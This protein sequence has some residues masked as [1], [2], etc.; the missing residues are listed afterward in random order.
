MHLESEDLVALARAINRSRPAGQ[1][2]PAVTA[3][4][5]AQV[6]ATARS[7]ADLMFPHPALTSDCTRR[8]FLTSAGV[9]WQAASVRPCGPQSGCASEPLPKGI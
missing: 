5:E 6:D 3:W 2:S 1:Y 9:D 7:V 8:L 4:R